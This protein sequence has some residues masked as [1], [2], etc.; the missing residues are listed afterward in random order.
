MKAIKWLMVCG[1]A[2]TLALRATAEPAYPFQLA[3]ASPAELVAPEHSINGL[4]LNLLYGANENV[5]GM[6]LGLI[7][8][9]AQD[10]CGLQLGLANLVGGNLTGFNMGLVNWAGGNVAGSE[11]GLINWAD[12]EVTGTQDSFL[13]NVSRGKASYQFSLAMSWADEV[14]G[15]QFGLVNRATKLTG[16][17]MGA[18]NVT[19]QLNGLQIGLLN[20]VLEDESPWK[21][22]PL[23]NARW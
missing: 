8:Y 9:T 5:N 12:G 21:F 15:G 1:L 20:C 16:L 19:G 17:Q 10:H 22:M 4:R 6:D 13:L 3:L 7:N 23:I 18:I 11:V 14:E 2:L